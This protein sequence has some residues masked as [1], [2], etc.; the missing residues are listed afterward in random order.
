MRQ[1]LVIFKNQYFDDFDHEHFGLVLPKK[2]GYELRCFFTRKA[3]S[4]FSPS[5]KPWLQIWLRSISR[6][7]G[8]WSRFIDTVFQDLEQFHTV[9]L[10]KKFNFKMKQQVISIFSIDFSK[11][12]VRLKHLPFFIQS[13]SISYWLQPLLVFRQLQMSN[14]IEGYVCVSYLID[15]FDCK[16]SNIFFC[17]FSAIPSCQISQWSLHSEWRKL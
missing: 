5:K 3:H 2:D 15:N 10:L 17:L 16:T 7:F 6:S 8:V 9:L 14:V 11:F 13:R 1:F 12:V 4:A